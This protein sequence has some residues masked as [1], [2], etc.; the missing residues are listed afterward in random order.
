[1]QLSF[2]TTLNKEQTHDVCK[3]IRNAFGYCKYF[4]QLHFCT[5]VCEVVFSFN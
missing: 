5:L 4:S 2:K 3:I 1:M